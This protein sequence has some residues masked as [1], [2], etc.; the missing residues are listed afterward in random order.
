MLPTWVN[1]IIVAVGIWLIIASFV[2]DYTGS[3]SW[4]TLIVG[5]IVVVLSCL[6]AIPKKKKETKK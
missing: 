5:I 2:L 6:V 4:N 3:V 1:W